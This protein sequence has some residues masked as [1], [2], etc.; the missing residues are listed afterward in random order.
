MYSGKCIF[1]AICSTQNL[2]IFDPQ[3]KLEVNLKRVEMTLKKGGDTK[4]S[5][6]LFEFFMIQLWKV[7][8]NPAHK[9]FFSFLTSV[10]VL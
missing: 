2:K 10:T 9:Q 7:N 1:P 5:G 6:I 3:T 4:R 8:S